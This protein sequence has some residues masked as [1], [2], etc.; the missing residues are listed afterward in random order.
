MIQASCSGQR[1]IVVF[2]YAAATTAAGWTDRWKQANT[3][4]A[5]IVLKVFLDI[6]TAPVN[7]IAGISTALQS[8]LI[9]IK[10]IRM[11]FRQAFGR[12]PVCSISPRPTVG[13][14]MS[15]LWWPSGA[16]WQLIATFNEWGEGT[17]IESAKEWETSP[18]YGARTDALH[19][20]GNSAPPPPS[21]TNV[22]PTQT[23][24]PS[25]TS[26]PPTQSRTG[27]DY[28]NSSHSNL[29]CNTS[30]K[31]AV[32]FDAHIHS[33]VHGQC[34]PDA[35]PGSIHYPQIHL[36]I[37]VIGAAGD[38]ACDPTSSS[39]NG[40]N[41]TSGSCRQKAVSDVML[42]SNLTAVLVLGDVQYE[43]GTLTKYQQSYDPSWGRL[44]SITRPAVGNHEYLTRIT[45]AT[46][47]RQP[48]IRRKVT[49]AITLAPG[50]S[51]PQLKLRQ[52]GGCGAAPAR[53]MAQ[54]GSGG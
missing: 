23:A 39:F 28:S 26:V 14:R 42:N 16:P 32:Y 9:A 30:A 49:T 1:L 4:N 38:V 15:K 50:I 12:K 25:V 13:I 8:P 24:Q 54:G 34:Q 11:Q 48:G 53:D 18:G 29:C 37:R 33:H 3:V 41:G 35:K 10:V 52:V 44:K 7:P 27:N 6:A 51:S 40:G 19:S 31:L 5:Y 20:N 36:E 43:D 17:S 22:P 2:V 47:A 46:L 45:S 21:P